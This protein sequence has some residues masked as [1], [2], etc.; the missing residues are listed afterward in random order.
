MEGG[1]DTAEEQVVHI[2]CP[3]P[4]ADDVRQYASDHKWKIHDSKL[5]I[6][7]R[8]IE[9]Q[10]NNVQ[11]DEGLSAGGPLKNGTWHNKA[12]SLMEKWFG[13]PKRGFNSPSS[14]LAIK[15][16]KDKER[17]YFNLQ[18]IN[19]AYNSFENNAY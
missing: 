8:A 5:K 15:D 17:H 12:W 10:R 11:R 4:S 6:D 19:Y 13:K 7:D 18:T 2:C 3:A 16:E 9:V 1:H 14:T